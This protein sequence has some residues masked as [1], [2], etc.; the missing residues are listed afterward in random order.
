MVQLGL[1]LSGVAWAQD[2]RAQDTG[3]SGAGVTTP[4][5]TLKTITLTGS[6]VETATSSLVYK[7]VSG[8]LH[9]AVTGCSVFPC[10]L[11]GQTADYTPVGNYNGNDSF[12][13]T[14]SLPQSG[15]HQK[16]GLSGVDHGR[17]RRQESKAE[18][19]AIYA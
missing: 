16:E 18:A 14:V 13:F 11:T 6:D 4:E 5:G 15:G 7:I 19:A 1:M 12:T 9:G 2:A 17:S 8:P 10:T 3:P